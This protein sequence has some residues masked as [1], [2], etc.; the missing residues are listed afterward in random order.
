[1][2]KCSDN[3][4]PKIGSSISLAVE[5]LRQGGIV[6]FPTETYYGLAVDPDNEK[7]IEKLFNIK[8]RDKEK[9]ILLLIQHPQQLSR[10]ITH[11]PD[12]YSE[13]MAKYW[14]GPLTLIFPAKKTVSKLLTA[15]SS[16]IGLRIS[17][18]PVAQSLVKKIGKAITATSANLSGLPAASTAEDVLKMFGRKV[19]YI[20]DGGVT[21]GQLGSTII[22]E[23]DKKL[24]VL[25][26]GKISIDEALL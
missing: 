19:D 16:T 21:E 15:N 10:F 5:I 13:L 2:S 24:I 20:L 9:P 14:P 12:K 3:S 26:P 4:L 11:T 7:A 25:R 23:G 8:K 6:A 18:H 17:P 22:G 1:M